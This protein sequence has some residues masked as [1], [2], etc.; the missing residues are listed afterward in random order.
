M[1][2]AIHSVLIEAPRAFSQLFQATTAH[3]H[4]FPNTFSRIILPFDF[5]IY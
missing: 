3:I 2:V 5:Y 4:I 1:L